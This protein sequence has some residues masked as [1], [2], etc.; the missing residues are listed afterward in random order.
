MN[1]VELLR[2]M[3]EACKVKCWCDLSIDSEDTL[4][5]RWR[6]EIKINKA[7]DKKAWY[8]DVTIPQRQL[9]RPHHLDQS[10][11]DAERS[12]ARLFEQMA[13]GE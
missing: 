4:L 5:L 10:L 7:G 8:L 2:K 13:G 3:R 9:R 12:I 1:A 11:G 6:G